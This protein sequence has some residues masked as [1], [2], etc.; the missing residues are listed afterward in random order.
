MRSG[1]FV[2]P[3][4]CGTLLLTYSVMMARAVFEFAQ[5][6]NPQNALKTSVEF[7]ARIE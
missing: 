6:G 2:V 1:V 5:P 4:S 3:D 7:A